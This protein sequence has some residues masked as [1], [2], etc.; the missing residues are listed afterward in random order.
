M[1]KI[2]LRVVTS[3]AC[4]KCGRAFDSMGPGNRLCKSCNSSNNSLSKLQKQPTTVMAPT[5][6]V[7]DTDA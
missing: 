4:L 3:R 6:G 5:A 1:D 2:E 7:E